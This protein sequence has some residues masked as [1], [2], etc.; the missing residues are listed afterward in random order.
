MV[1]RCRSRS[2]GA[3]RSKSFEPE[4][5]EQTCI[6][7]DCAIGVRVRMYRLQHKFFY[8]TTIDVFSVDA[9]G[10]IENTSQVF[11]PDDRF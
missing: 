3:P 9:A 5:V 1:G 10:A 4:L 11:Q 2:V 8:L 6:I 7:T